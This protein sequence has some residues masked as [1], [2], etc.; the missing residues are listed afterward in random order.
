MNGKE[1]APDGLKDDPAADPHM[2]AIGTCDGSAAFPSRT[3]FLAFDGRHG[4][5]LIL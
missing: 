5:N 2:K 4:Y 3:G 1:K